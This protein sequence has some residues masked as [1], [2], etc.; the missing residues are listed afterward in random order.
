MGFE[1]GRGFMPGVRVYNRLLLLLD[2]GWDLDRRFWPGGSRTHHGRLVRR[3]LPWSLRGIT[4]PR[5]EDRGQSG[6]PAIPRGTLRGVS[7]EPGLAANRTH[8]GVN[9]PS[10]PHRCNTPLFT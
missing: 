6:P 10:L 9:S 1:L 5:S 2:M 3:P 8:P 7:P 4:A